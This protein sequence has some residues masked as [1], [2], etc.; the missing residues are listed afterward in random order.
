MLP[1]CSTCQITNDSASRSWKS[2]PKYSPSSK[3]VKLIGVLHNVK[4]V[5]CLSDVFSFY[6]VYVVPHS[7]RRNSNCMG[8]CFSDLV[9]RHVLYITQYSHF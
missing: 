1:L 7:L 9:C 4:N 5:M 2:R 6:P 3:E 8:V